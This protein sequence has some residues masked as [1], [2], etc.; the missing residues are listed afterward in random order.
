MSRRGRTGSGAAPGRRILDTVNRFDR[1]IDTTVGRYRGRGGLERPLYVLS[2][3]ANHSIL[4][5]G[6][7]LADAVVG[8]PVHRRQA[9][10]RST[11]LVVEQALV[12]GV[13]K[14]VFRRGRPEST[15]TH[16]YRLRTPRT[17]SFPSGHASAGACAATLLSEDLGVAPVWWTTA[18]VVSASRIYVGVHHASDIIGGLVVGRVLALC[19]QRVWPSDAP[20]LL[21]D[22]PD[23]H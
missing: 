14:S 4:W 10:R 20:S 9:L 21:R 6:I 2:E 16:Q 23:G 19:A 8:G 17:T 12:N 11:I 3:A 7:N 22:L 1:V 18:G 15:T 13:V 5:H